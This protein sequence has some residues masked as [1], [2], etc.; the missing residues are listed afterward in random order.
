MAY[1]EDSPPMEKP[2]GILSTGE[3][4]PT[5][6]LSP[7]GEH[8]VPEKDDYSDAETVHAGTMLEAMKAGDT[9]AFRD[10]LAAFVRECV[11]N[12]NKGKS[13]E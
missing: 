12:Y 13:L 5:M 2:K 6:G 3:T 8:M 11:R 9:E 7:M 10:S 4:L 1:E